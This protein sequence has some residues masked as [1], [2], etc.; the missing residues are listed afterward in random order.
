MNIIGK[1][2][3]LKTAQQLSLKTAL[4]SIALHGATQEIIKALMPHEQLIKGVTHAQLIVYDSGII[5]TE[6]LEQHHEIW[7]AVIN[8]QEII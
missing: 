8:A 2:R 1:I 7:S 6:R 5:E 3:K 4:N